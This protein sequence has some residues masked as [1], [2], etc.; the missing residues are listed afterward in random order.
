MKVWHITYSNNIDFI[1]IVLMFS[2]SQRRQPGWSI[3]HDTIW[4][5]YTWRWVLT[6]QFTTKSFSGWSIY[7]DGQLRLTLF[8]SSDTCTR[9]HYNLSTQQKWKKTVKKNVLAQQIPRLQFIFFPNGRY[10]RLFA[11]HKQMASALL[12]AHC[13]PGPVTQKYCLPS[14][15]HL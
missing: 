10:I 7:S 15:F 13:T 2:W 5:P 1:S 6:F 11:A 9:I 4:K 14:E 12:T 8:N 3:Q